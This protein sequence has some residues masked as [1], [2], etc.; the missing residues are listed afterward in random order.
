MTN[1]DINYSYEGSNEKE[2]SIYLKKYKEYSYKERIEKY[3]NKELSNLADQAEQKAL[4][5]SALSKIFFLTDSPE[6]FPFPYIKDNRNCSFKIENNILNSEIFS[7]FYILKTLSISIKSI[8]VNELLN[9]GINTRSI[10]TNNGVHIFLNY[11]HSENYANWRPEGQIISTLYD[12]DKNQVEK[13]IALPGNKFCSF[14]NEGSANIF[15]IITNDESIIIKKIWYSGDEVQ[16]PIKYKNTI[17]L[18]DNLTFLAASEN[19]IYSYDPLYTKDSRQ[20]IKVLYESKYR[21]NITCVK[22]IGKT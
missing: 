10:S 15:K 18:I 17:T 9:K 6:S 7:I 20:I 11:M 13:L 19:K 2:P 1:D 5:H 8:N 12:H 16:C 21:H 22:Q 4:L 14:D 3:I